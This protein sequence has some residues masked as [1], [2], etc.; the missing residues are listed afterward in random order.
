MDVNF[1]T[2]D[3]FSA[4]AVVYWLALILFCSYFI[5]S[6]ATA[7]VYCNFRCVL[8]LGWIL[9]VIA[10]TVPSQHHTF[11]FI[12]PAACR[13]TWHLARTRMCLLTA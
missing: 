1:M 9:L 7:V 6:L 11:L 3:V 5:V 8:L 12:P 13:I 10:Q 4:W 2:W